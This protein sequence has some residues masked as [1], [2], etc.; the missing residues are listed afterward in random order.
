MGKALNSEGYCIYDFTTT[1]KAKSMTKI[2]IGRSWAGTQCSVNL[3][4]L[5][6]VKMSLSH[7]SDTGVFVLFYLVLAFFPRGK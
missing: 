2:T 6:I 4:D 7:L 1:P 3:C 5:L